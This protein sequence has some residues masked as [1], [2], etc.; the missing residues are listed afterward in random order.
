MGASGG[1]G[2]PQ[3]RLKITKIV[4]PAPG[5]SFMGCCG[6]R[7][8]VGPDVGATPTAAYTCTLPSSSVVLTKVTAT[9][10]GTCGTG[11]A[12]VGLKIWTTTLPATAEFVG[13]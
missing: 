7:F 9:D 2:G 13:R 10:V 12:L 8:S 6:M 4:T 3:P 1:P 5:A 11:G